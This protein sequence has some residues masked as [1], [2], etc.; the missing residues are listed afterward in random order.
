L[1]SKTLFRSCIAAVLI[2]VLALCAY[3]RITSRR[4]IDAVEALIAE[5]EREA[6]QHVPILRELDEYM[7]LKAV[8]QRQQADCAP[9][10]AG[11]TAHE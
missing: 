11:E 10:A 6:A 9:P 1:T 8:V 2:S 5:R 4:R 3:D 7:R